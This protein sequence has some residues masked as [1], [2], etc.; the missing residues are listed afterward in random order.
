MDHDR[1]IRVMMDGL[2]FVGVA[3]FA[4][5]TKAWAD[6]KIMPAEGI[7]WV[8]IFLGFGNLLTAALAWLLRAQVQAVHDTFNSK[9]D[10][11][12]ELTAAASKAEGV[13]EEKARSKEKLVARDAALEEGAKAERKRESKP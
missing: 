8:A 10:K 5:L 2:I 12:L 1:I 6:G 3:G 9:M 13:L 4:I 7:P 11:L